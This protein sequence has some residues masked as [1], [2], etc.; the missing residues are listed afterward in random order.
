MKKILLPVIQVLLTV[1]LLW[2][3]FRDPQQNAK[4]LAA[5]GKAK[6]DGG[7]WWFLPGIAALGAAL[8][9]G[10][11]MVMVWL[12]VPLVFEVEPF[13]PFEAGAPLR[14]ATICRVSCISWA[15]AALYWFGGACTVRSIGCS[16]TCACWLVAMDAVFTRAGA[17]AAWL[18]YCGMGCA[19]INPIMV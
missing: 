18:K 12:S 13:E 19:A 6:A 8:P 2:W 17:A 7:L 11:V 9:P 1:V 14:T 3:I 5:I 16:I 4:M 10:P 15:M